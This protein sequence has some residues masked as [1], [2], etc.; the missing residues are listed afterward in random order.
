MGYPM[1]HAQVAESLI[2][3][4]YSEDPDLAGIVEAF[5]SE[6]PERLAQMERSFQCLDWEGLRQTA[7]QL[8]GAAGS[9][10]FQPITDLSAR[11]ENSVREMRCETGVRQALDDLTDLCQRARPRPAI[12]RT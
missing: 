1:Q 7:H 6:L 5:V 4:K 12:A 10:G 2:Y 11:L 8:R 9:Y 3:S